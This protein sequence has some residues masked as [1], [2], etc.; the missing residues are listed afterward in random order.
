MK[1]LKK[2]I[3]LQLSFI[4]IGCGSIRK[5]EDGAYIASYKAD[6][7]GS[8]L[9][10]NKDKA[11]MLSEVQ[12]DAV[13]TSV[14][15]FTNSLKL[16]DKI[17]ADQLVEITEAVT[18]L[19]ERTEAVNILRDAL[20][21]LAEMKNSGDL[22]QITETLFCKIIESAET[23]ALTDKLKN[24]AKKLNAE[25][26]LTKQQY[27]LFDKISPEDFKQLKLDKN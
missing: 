20:Y 23:I 15:K 22:D 1:V 11:T 4:L 12:P 19:G 27:L 5:L 18:S 25:V 14:M 16:K 26:A 3:L 2:I 6:D 24:E 7:R 10:V 21:R 13:I 8:L 17:E 9:F